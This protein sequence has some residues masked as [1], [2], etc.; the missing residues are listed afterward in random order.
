MS[1]FEFVILLGFVIFVLLLSTFL[2]SSTNLLSAR[3]FTEGVKATLL[4]RI[5]FYFGLPVG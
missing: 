4:Q 5:K 2:L 1:V 3:D